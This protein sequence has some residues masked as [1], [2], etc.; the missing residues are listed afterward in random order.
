MSSDFQGMDVDAAE[1]VATAIETFSGDLEGLFEAALSAASSAEWLGPDADE[2]KSNFESTV[3]GQ[4]D[5]IRGVADALAKE[6]RADIDEQNQA[7]SN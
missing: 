7:S 5:A 4:I 1:G 3:T 6:L 2:Y